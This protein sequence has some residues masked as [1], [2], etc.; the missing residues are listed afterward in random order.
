M[1]DEPPWTA[2]G[3]ITTATGAC[4]TGFGITIGGTG[5]PNKPYLLTVAHC[6]SGNGVIVKD[7]HNDR[8][9]VTAYENRSID[10]TLIDVN[11]VSGYMFD[12]AWNDI[13]GKREKVVGTIHATDGLS[14]CNSGS[15]AG[16]RCGLIV[17]NTNASWSA[18]GTTV[19]GLDVSP[20]TSNGVAVGKG[21]SG[22]PTLTN[23]SVSRE[24]KAAGIISAGGQSVPCTGSY[25][26]STC[27]HHA[28]IV[29]I[30]NAQRG[31]VVVLG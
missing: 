10:S 12:G 31:G 9:G 2:G 1:N 11:L 18:A 4:S 7:G 30:Q 26:T 17:S 15:A 21:D 22:G 19:H 14:V 3:R 8:I 23:T 13:T 6:F 24:I 20:N 25:D 16:V 28:Y 27:Y 29:P 5:I